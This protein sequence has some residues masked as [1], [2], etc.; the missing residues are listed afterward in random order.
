MLTH[1]TQYCVLEKDRETK[2]ERS[3][4]S[5]VIVDDSDELCSISKSEFIG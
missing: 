3:D 4:L 2:D 1:P 5:E